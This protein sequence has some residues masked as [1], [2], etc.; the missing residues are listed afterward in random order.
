MSPFSL[1]DDESGLI[2]TSNKNA[3]GAPFVMPTPEKRNHIP[4][5]TLHDIEPS[6]SEK[7]RLGV[8]YLRYL[9]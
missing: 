2:E 5:G 6:S 1:N 8:S 3:S 9:K 4:V 7:F